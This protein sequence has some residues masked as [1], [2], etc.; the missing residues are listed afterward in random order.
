MSAPRP[1]APASVSGSAFTVDVPTLADVPALARVHVRGWEVAY[2][3]V[4][5][6]E[7]WFGQPAIERRIE[8]WTRWLTPGT[9]RKSVV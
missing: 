3:H 1:A 8:Q 2:G 7:E 4:L 5:A 6:G 9:D